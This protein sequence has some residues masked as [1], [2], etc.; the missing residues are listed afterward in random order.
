MGLWILLWIFLLIWQ[1]ILLFCLF[2]EGFGSTEFGVHYF[3][4][5][6]WLIDF[7][8]T[9]LIYVRS[10]NE[11]IQQARDCCLIIFLFFSFFL[12]F[13]LF[14]FS[15]FFLSS[16]LSSWYSK[17]TQCVQIVIKVQ[18]EIIQFQSCNREG[19]Y[20]F[21]CSYLFSDSACTVVRRDQEN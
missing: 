13:F 3:F 9:K 6:C 20:L 12:F 8:I 14:L 4:V 2:D 7:I 17:E 11:V 5:F 1:Q 18:H 10:V 15:Y 19:R 16:Y 21:S